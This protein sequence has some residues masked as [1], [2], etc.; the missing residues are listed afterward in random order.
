MTGRIRIGRV[1]GGLAGITVAI[2]LSKHRHVDVHVYESSPQFTERGAGIG[3]PPLALE[4]GAVEADAARL[5]IVCTDR[6]PY[7]M[8]RAPLLQTLLSLLP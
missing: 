2:A 8:N 7:P 3:L 4:A 1:G 6:L 5:V